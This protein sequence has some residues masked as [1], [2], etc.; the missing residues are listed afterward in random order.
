VNKSKCMGA[1]WRSEKDEIYNR[2]TDRKER[3][4][5]RALCTWFVYLCMHSLVL[6]ERLWAWETST[7]RFDW[8]LGKKNKKTKR[9]QQ[10]R[11]DRK[12]QVR[13][14]NYDYCTFIGFLSVSVFSF[15]GLRVMSNNVVQQ[16]NSEHLSP[17]I[18]NKIL[19]KNLFSLTSHLFPSN[20]QWGTDRIASSEGKIFLNEKVKRHEEKW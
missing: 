8:F 15:W 1:I 6:R 7:R 17:Y 14:K 3:R 18:A 19:C 2:W 20:F 11:K 4:G 5:P 16:L 13:N 9:G 12:S 10:E